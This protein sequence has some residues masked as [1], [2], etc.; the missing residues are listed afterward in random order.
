[1]EPVNL[2]KLDGKKLKEFLNSFDYVFSD[3]DGVLWTTA[4]LP[5]VGKFFELIK[6]F[7]KKVHFV[8]NNSIRTKENY[9][10][11]FQDAGIKDG[12]N[13]LTIPSTAIAEYLKSVNFN[14]AVY[15]VTCPE[16]VAVL[17]SNGFKCKE[18]PEIGTHYYGDYI[19]YLADDE[20]IGA[21]VFDSDFKVNLPKMYKALTYLKRPEVLFING[22][23]DRYVTLEKESL[24]LGT[25]VFSEI[26]SQESKR[27]PIL[28]GKPGLAFGEFAMKRAGVTDASRVLFIGDMI[29]Q[30]VGLGRAV[31]FQTMLVLTNKTKEEML[32]HPT[33]KP[34]YYADSLGSLVPVLSKV[35]NNYVNEI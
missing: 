16:T 34:D 24:A 35:L 20:E 6:G 12:I 29:E 25:G 15:C 30:D 18:G 32:S 14:K 4:P 3:C 33:L 13:N 26:V 8:S 31:G 9:D 1:M 10:S 19:K 23:T 5:G 11:N 17:E 28:L 22:A 7:G 21:V 2:M 27:T